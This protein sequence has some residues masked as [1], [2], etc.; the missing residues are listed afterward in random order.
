[1][2]A[3]LDQLARRQ[4]VW[5]ADSQRIAYQAVSSGYPELDQQLGGGLPATGLIDIQTQAGIGE[6]RLLLPYLQQQQQSQRLLVFIAPPAELSAD[7]LA[8]AG[9]DLNQ[10]LV[11]TPQTAQ[12][13]AGDINIAQPHSNAKKVSA[14]QE[15]LWAAEQCL[16]SGCCATVLL[17]PAAISLAQA[18]RL[19]LAAEHGAASMVLFRNQSQ[20]LSLPV[21]LSVSLQA[22]PQGLQLTVLKRKGSWPAAP[23]LINMQHTWPALCVAAGAGEPIR[24]AG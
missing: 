2:S 12:P 6:L 15:A 10:L 18:R 22:D 5:H 21:N 13:Q 7:M 24:R 11:I 20:A 8:G 9:L 23:F 19:Q 1:M 4:L 17:W 3:L 16:Q 14:K